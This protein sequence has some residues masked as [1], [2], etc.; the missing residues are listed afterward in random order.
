MVNAYLVNLHLPNDV[1]FE[2]LR[3]T[4]GMLATITSKNTKQARDDDR[5]GLDS[6]GG[7]SQVGRRHELGRPSRHSRQFCSP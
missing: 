5:E 3:V 1:V 2:N 4:E 7:A 6:G